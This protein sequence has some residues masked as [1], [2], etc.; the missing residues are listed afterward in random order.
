MRIAAFILT[1]VLFIPFANAQNERD[2]LE[3]KEALNLNGEGDDYGPVFT[4]SATLFFTSS[5]RDP[6][7]EKVMKNNHNICVSTVENDELSAPNQAFGMVNS[8][9]HEAVAGSS[10]DRQILFIYKVFNGGDI[11]CINKTGDKW[12]MPKKLPFNSA[13]HESSAVKYGN[14]YLFVSDRPGGLGGH[15]IYKL[16]EDENGNFSKP[17]NVSELNSE[18]DENHLSI[19]GDGKTLYYSSKGFSSMGGYDIFMSKRVGDTWSKP[20]NMGR[21]INSG[22]NDITLTRDANGKYWFAS[23]RPSET[24]GGYNIYCAEE[25]KVRKTIPVILAGLAPIEENETGKITQLINSVELEGYNRD[26]PA[27]VMADISGVKDSLSVFKVKDLAISSKLNLISDPEKQVIDIRMLYKRVENLTLD[28][29]EEQID[30]EP[31]FYKVQ[32]GTFT[33]LNSIIEFNKLF[34]NLGDKVLMISNKDHTR[35]LLRETWE[36]IG[37]AAEMQKKCL[38]EWGAVPDTFIG[39]YDGKG[40]RIIIYFDKEKENYILLR[41]EDQFEDIF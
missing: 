14:T 15:D 3:I 34:P 1:L 4:D 35:F 22:Q 29:V 10:D 6:K 28:E 31:R 11:F 26:F 39:V 36:E 41:P 13:Y 5:R 37:P 12:S 18:T 30:F 7:T 24:N 21:I 38:F 25:K 40:K 2:T 33:R 17:E 19:S 23:D 27:K 9:N 20:V 8:D 32:V 16:T